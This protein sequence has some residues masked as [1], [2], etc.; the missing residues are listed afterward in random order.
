MAEF[1]PEAGTASEKEPTTAKVIATVEEALNAALTAKG[2]E[3]EEYNPFMV[4]R[5]LSYFQDTILYARLQAFEY[6]RDLNSPSF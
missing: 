2:E 1:I 4:N 6:L 3:K 5:G